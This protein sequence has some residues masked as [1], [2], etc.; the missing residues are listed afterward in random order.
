MKIFMSWCTKVQTPDQKRQRHVLSICFIF[1]DDIVSETKVDVKVWDADKV[2]F[3]DMWGSISMS[4]KDIVEGTLDKLGNVASW[5]QQERVVF[6]GWTPIDGKSEHN[7][8]V[9]LNMK[10]SFHPKYP[11]P[12]MDIFNGDAINQKTNSEKGKENIRKQQSEFLDV[13]VA[14]E[15]NNGIISVTI[16]Q[17]VDLEIGDPQVLPTDEKFRHPYRPDSVVSPYAV[18]YINDNKVYQTRT[19]LRNPSP[20]SR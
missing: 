9:K 16:H 18:L 15:H 7:S 6:D 20:V 5:C 17:A 13:P 14:P 4:V 1:L 10:M 19:K 11:T 8:K 2:K 12:N 3:D